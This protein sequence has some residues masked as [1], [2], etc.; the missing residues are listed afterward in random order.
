MGELEK[1]YYENTSRYTPASTIYNIHLY[2][3]VQL[4]NFLPIDIV[5][6]TPGRIEEIAASAALQMP[7]IDPNQSTIV[8]KVCNV[9]VLKN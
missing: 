7:T 2:P 9:L 3:A 8:I 6:I 4:K 1:V 5:I